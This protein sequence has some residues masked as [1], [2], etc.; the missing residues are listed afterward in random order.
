M[1]PDSR[2]DERGIALG[3]AYSS[4]ESLR[5]A[6]RTRTG[7][8]SSRKRGLWVKG[9]TSGATQELIRVDL[10]CDRDT[11]RFVVRQVG[12]AHRIATDSGEMCVG[13]ARAQ[14]RDQAGAELVAGGFAG[15]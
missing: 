13:E 8:Y 4:H 9:A 1:R 10:D 11:L 14:F 6:V 2:S 7:V 5:E 15:A 3:L 12:G